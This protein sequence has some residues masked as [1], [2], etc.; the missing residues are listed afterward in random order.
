MGNGMSDLEIAAIRERANAATGGDWMSCLGSGRNV[1]T[2]IKAEF[3]PDGRTVFVADFLPE[4]ALDWAEQDHRPNMQFV[5]HARTDIPAL[6]DLAEWQA[7]EIVRLKALAEEALDHVHSLWNQFALE[8]ESPK[9]D[10]CKRGRHHSFLSDLEAAEPFLRDLGMID[11]Y[12]AQTQSAGD[13]LK[14]FMERV[15]ETPNAG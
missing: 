6:C 7:A 4:Y 12:G 15:E 14:A 13:A 2:A 3:Q 1:M 10:W 8:V 9:D 5:C 11:E